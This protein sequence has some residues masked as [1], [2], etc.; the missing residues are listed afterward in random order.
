MSQPPVQFKL[1]SRSAIAEARHI[2]FSGIA[3]RPSGVFVISLD[4]EL[5]WGMRHL[6]SVRDYLPR[7]VGARATVPALLRLF[8]EYSIHATW[9]TVGFLFFDRVRTLMEYAPQQRPQYRDRRLCPYS[10]LPPD[11]AREDRES[12]FFA[13]TLIRLIADTANQEVATHTF[14]HYF[15]LEDGQN[16]ETFRQDLLAARAA[17]QRLGFVLSSIVFP[18]N[19]FSSE[20]VRT[21]L[22]IG[23]TAYRGNPSSWIY[24]EA[25]R[26]Q[27]YR[28]RR[29]AR[30]VDT[31][32]PI[33]IGNSGPLVSSTGEAPVN[34]PGSRFLRP[35]TR[36]LRKLDPLRL[37]RIKNEMRIAATRG[38]L[39][40]LWWHP[41]NFG[42]DAEYNL[43]FLGEILKYY[44][45][46]RE[47]YGFESANMGEI[48][49]YCLTEGSEIRADSAI[50]K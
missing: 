46:L 36:S 39:Y 10:D 16:I 21:C 49:K 38:L 15:C 2:A 11:D 31:Y 1:Y 26:K 17:A 9:A 30:L 45:S 4:F 29:F 24:R 18:Q 8:T 43:A 25:A 34:V 42:L 32:V 33:T 5:Y 28:I 20:H 50:A 22:E 14:S 3:P 41:H 7:L 40:H 44:R 47:K 27:Q 37:Q 35:Y 13:P 12:I 48:V 19:A 23:I 6:A